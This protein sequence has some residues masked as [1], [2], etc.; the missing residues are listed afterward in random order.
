MFGPA[1][2]AVPCRADF[3]CVFFEYR[4]GGIACQP[5]VVPPL[6]TP[7]DRPNQILGPSQNGLVLLRPAGLLF[8]RP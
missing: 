3:E 5:N 7:V 6:P 1:I 2:A 8:L 4:R